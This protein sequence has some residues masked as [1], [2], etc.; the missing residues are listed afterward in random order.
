MPIAD[1]R[2]AYD[3]LAPAYDALTADYCHE[4]WLDELERL[5]LRHGLAGR[6]VLDVACGTGKSFLPLLAKGYRVVACDISEAM[7][8][9]AAPKAPGVRLVHTDMR[10]LGRLGTFDLVTC[11][12][13]LVTA[14]QEGLKVTVVLLVNHGY[15]S[16]HGLQRATT[17]TSFGNEFRHR[18]AGASAPDGAFVEVDYAANAASLGCC[19]VDVRDVDRLR[20][21]LESARAERRPSVIACHVEPR[22]SLLGGGAFWDLGVPRASED[23]QVLRLTRDH[24]ER[25]RRQRSYL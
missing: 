21:A 24:A 25:A 13:E 2:E 11:L 14:V 4:R 1:A 18:Q 19:A 5:A 8:A 3:R 7:L 20:A 15:Q 6:R 23:E 12:T 10:R 22:R 16:I 9:V 17:G